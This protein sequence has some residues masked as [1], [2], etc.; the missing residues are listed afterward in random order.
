MWRFGVSKGTGESKHPGKIREK[1]AEKQRFQ[2]IVSPIWIFADCVAVD[3]V[4]CELFSDAETG[5]NTGNL[6]FANG[7]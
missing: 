6:R 3:A 1:W 7:M 4:W 2:P 5:K